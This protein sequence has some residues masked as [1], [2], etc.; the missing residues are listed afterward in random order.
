MAECPSCGRVNVGDARFCSGCGLELVVSTIEEIRKTV[1]VVFCDVVGSTALGERLDPESVRRAIGRYFDEARV[2]IERHGGTVEKFIGDAVMSVF[3]I[4]KLH[5]DD[6]LRAARAAC[7][8]REAVAV[9]GR[10]L[11]AELGVGIEV[12]IGVATGEVVAGD[13][14]AGQAFVT[15]DVVNVAAR[16]E[17]AAAPGE[18]L[19]AERT[20]ELVRA[21][22]RVEPLGPIDLKG[23]SAPVDAW[24]LLE[25]PGEP[26][27]PPAFES[28]FVGRARELAALSQVLE[29]TVES[30]SCQLC[31]VVGPPGIGKSRL[32]EEF[33]RAATNGHRVVTGRCLPYGEGITYW[34]LTE[35]V[36]ALGGP[37]HVRELLAGDE[38]G[39]LVAERISGV[40]GTAEPSGP[41]EESFWAFRKL[42][43]ALA[44]QRPLIAIVDELQWAEPTLLDLLEYLVTFAADEPILLLCLS[45]PE[46]LDERP[47]WAAPRRAATVVAL[48][49]LGEAES[50]ALVETIA[51]TQGVPEADLARIVATAEGN[52][53]FLEQLLAYRVG[54]GNGE[55]AI[56]PNIQTLL[57][58]RIDRLEPEERAVLVRAAVEGKTFHRGAL[59]ALLTERAR[60]MLGARLISLVRQELIRPDRSQFSGDDGFRFGHSLIHDAAYEAAS[61]ELR[62]EAHERYADWLEER[63]GQQVMQ[64]E[65]ILGY[66]LEQAQRFRTELGR[67]DAALSRRAAERL[68]SAGE[69]ARARGDVPAAINLLERS[70]A[71]APMPRDV[72]ADV[73]YSLGIARME[74]GDLAEAERAWSDAVE[75]AR[76]AG[77]VRIA[78]R[79]E[80]ERVSVR[81]RTGGATIEELRAEAERAIPVLERLGD[82]GGLARA[83]LR[84]SEA[85]DS[86]A[87]EEEAAERSRVHARR[88]QLPRDEEDALFAS[89][90][91]ALYGERSVVEVTELCTTLL[92]EADGPLAEV[93]TLEILAALTVRAGAVAE[94]RRL[95]RDADRL[96]RELGMRHREAVNWQ[97]WGRSELVAG[98]SAMAVTAFRQSI[99]QFEQI[100]DAFHAGVAG[101]LLAHAL[102]DQGRYDDA[103][104]ALDRRE[105]PVIAP[106]ARARVL[107]ES[108]QLDE[109][110]ACAHQALAASAELGWPE[111]RAQ[112]LV[113]LAEVWRTADQPAKEA[114]ALHEALE[115]YERKGIAPAADRVRVRLN[116]LEALRAT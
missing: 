52:P 96:Y 84:L 64:Y 45:R 33:T 68:A 65:E 54:G 89:L 110:L 112:V 13:H 59:A 7:E 87:G 28:S 26:G 85:S 15:G 4:P 109:A 42:F 51:A 103:A 31:T 66:H 9:L 76:R 61:K 70:I 98:D 95:Y 44:R 19:L 79:A 77:D 37:N 41:P 94:G 39:A 1:T 10:E 56:P 8:L 97:C 75:R 49:P 69:R 46:L 29:R 86:L 14:T 43:E 32:A 57:A 63:A 5:E 50:S 102:C 12:R 47:T 113:S 106:S 36:Q 101:A 100:G 91:A 30:R 21:A 34:P 22:V 80:L 40:V 53:L 88:A 116:E 73:L 104:A 81:E 2:T 74:A 67:A 93:G 17:Q 71:V 55:P 3:G 62:A 108:A 60:P 111:G 48:E 99:E 25:V 115:L 83:W 107:A 27:G 72:P 11:E 78:T 114:T 90:S 23:K 35:I 18:I 92:A 82:E 20:H 16:L 24:R 58:A 38:D 105:F 6:A